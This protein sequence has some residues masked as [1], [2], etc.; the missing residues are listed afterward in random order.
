MASYFSFFLQPIPPPLLTSLKSAQVLAQFYDPDHIL[1][2][3]CLESYEVLLNGLLR[4]C[5]VLQLS[6][7]FRHKCLFNFMK[8]SLSLGRSFLSFTTGLMLPFLKW[9]I[10]PPPPHTMAPWCLQ[11]C[12]IY[13]SLLKP[14]WR[15]PAPSSFKL[16]TKDVIGIKNWNIKIIIMISEIM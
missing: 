7:Y 10:L 15:P 8:F 6:S 4:R 3:T 12:H 14:G 5:S 9:K 13:L 2:N 11:N 16:W 1:L